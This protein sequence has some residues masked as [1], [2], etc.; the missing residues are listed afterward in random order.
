MTNLI[1]AR[2]THIRSELD[3]LV[4]TQIESLSSDLATRITEM[5]AVAT[6]LETSTREQIDIGVDNSERT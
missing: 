3:G 6:N 4:Q 2:F 5:E 1:D